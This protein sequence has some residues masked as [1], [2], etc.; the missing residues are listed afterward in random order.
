MKL[1]ILVVITGEDKLRSAK[2][3]LE[4]LKKEN[5]NARVRIEVRL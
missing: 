4:E 5:P 3:L 2:S 1:E